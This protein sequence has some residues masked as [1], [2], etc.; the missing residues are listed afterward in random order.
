MSQIGPAPSGPLSGSV[1]PTM[2]QMMGT[3]EGGQSSS[4]SFIASPGDGGG[5][6][7]GIAP[8]TGMFFLPPPDEGTAPPPNFQ[9]PPCDPN[10]PNCHLSSPS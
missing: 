4:G 8:R 9:P 2:T 1:Q 5:K 7:T 6:A 3:Q 10:D